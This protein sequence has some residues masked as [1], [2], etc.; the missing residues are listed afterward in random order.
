MKKNELKAAQLLT[1]GLDERRASK[2]FPIVRDVQYEV[3]YRGGDPRSGIGTTINVSSA[4]VLFTAPDALGPGDR[5]RLSIN[6][7][8]QLDGKHAL[9]LVA[10]GWITRCSDTNVAMEIVSHAFRTGLLGA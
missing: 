1:D 6:W 4:G 2:R 3:T 8:A 7:P 10:Q 5:I 9:T